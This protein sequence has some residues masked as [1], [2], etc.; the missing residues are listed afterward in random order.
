MYDPK[1]KLFTLM[2][3]CFPTHHLQFARD[4][5]NTLWLSSANV[6]Y[7]GPVIGWFNRRVYEQTHDEAEAQ[8]WTALILDTNGNGV[9]DSYTEPDEPLDPA[10]DR[11]LNVNIYGIAPS[12][13]DGSIWGSVLGFPGGVVRLDPGANPPA[14]A[15]T[16]Y[17]EAPWN[18]PRAP[19]HGYSPRGMDIDRRGVVWT[20]LASGH[21]A[22][23]DRRK[24]RSP[25][26]GPTATG[27]QCPEGWNMYRLPGPQFKGVTESGS[28]ESSYYTWVDQFNTFGLGNDVP[29]A[30]GNNSDSLLALV[31]GSF[32]TL[33]VPYPMG[34]FAKGM[35]GRIDNPEG[36]WKG[37]GLWSTYS[38]RTP[39]HIE[40]GKGTTSKVVHFQLRPNPLAR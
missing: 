23:F 28:A 9:R 12:P 5:D 8:G 40:G 16:Q 17:F 39:F 7:S 10:K 18:D 24:C 4:K 26:N 6:N 11:R 25:L 38:T 19:V 34:F 3:T 37:R 27:T 1:A 2:D 21:L 13:A 32:V 15:L 29:I 30:T 14:T 33:R 22:S 20:S 35:D 36:G 31:N